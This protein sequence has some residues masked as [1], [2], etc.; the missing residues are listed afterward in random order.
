MAIAPVTTGQRAS[1]S[2]ASF[3]A[4]R[5]AHQAYLI[6]H[7]GFTVLPIVMV[8]TTSPCAILACCSARWRWHG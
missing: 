4:A 6:L 3:T 8:F 2:F 5:P 7:L 1:I